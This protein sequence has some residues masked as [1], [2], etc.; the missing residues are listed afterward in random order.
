MAY[1]SSLP[2]PLVLQSFSNMGMR[3]VPPLD[4]AV[5]QDC[6]GHTCVGMFINYIAE[7]TGYSVPAAFNPAAACCRCGRGYG[8]PTRF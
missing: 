7:M 2:C 8:L 3:M 6:A 1:L 5:R 4:G